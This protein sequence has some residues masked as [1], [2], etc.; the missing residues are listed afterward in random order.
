MK[1]PLHRHGH[2]DLPQRPR[3]PHADTRAHTVSEPLT[4]ASLLK[5]PRDVRGRHRVEP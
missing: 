3:A 1:A 5:T 2:L 4:G